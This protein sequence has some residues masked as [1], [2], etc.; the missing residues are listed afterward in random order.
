MRSGT[1]EF[2]NRRGFLARMT[3][4]ATPGKRD[5]RSIHSSPSLKGGGTSL[6]EAGTI[7][8]LLAEAHAS[9]RTE[10]HESGSQSR[11]TACHSS[12]HLD[13]VSEQ[14][15]AAQ[16]ALAASHQQVLYMITEC[17]EA[18]ARELRML[19][20]L[21]NSSDD[22]N[23]PATKSP[24]RSPTALVVP[25]P[26]FPS[27][28]QRRS[29]SESSAAHPHACPGTPGEDLP[30]QLTSVV[31]GETVNSNTP[32]FVLDRLPE[33][34]EKLSDRS[35]KERGRSAKHG[36][37]DIGD[38]Q[39][40]RCSMG[41]A[42]S[43]FA[44]LDQNRLKAKIRQSIAKPVYNVT[45]YYKSDG[46]WQS[47]ARSSWFEQLTLIVI[48][49]NAVWIGIDTD[50][51]KSVLLAADAFFI[52]MENFFCLFFFSE[53]VVRY[54]S[55]RQTLQALRDSWFVFDSILVGITIMET[56][57]MT[58]VLIAASNGSSGATLNLFDTDAS[59]LRLL[60]LL[61]LSRMAR[62]ARLFRA[63]PEL[64]I[65]M[66]GLVAAIRSVL[67]TLL[68]LTIIIYVFGIAFTSLMDGTH[69]GGAYFST[70]LHSMG[71][72]LLH[73]VFLE[74]I[75]DV[76]HIAAAESPF[77]GALLLLFVLIASFLVVNMLIGVMVETVHVVSAVER[78]QLSVTFTKDKLQHM[79]QTTNLDANGDNKIS[80]AEFCAL[81]QIPD[82]V[83]AL[84]ELGVDV[85]GLVDL[86]EFVFESGSQLEFPA[87]MDMVLQLRGS[88]KATVKDIVDLRKCMRQEI[89]NLRKTVERVAGF[90]RAGLSSC[91]LRAQG[92][93]GS[94]GLGT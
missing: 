12:A 49:I 20:E 42:S 16:R 15:V 56:W 86:S 66:K 74:D 31:P 28:A 81:L 78:E 69:P 22:N 80:K 83:R 63:I 37:L 27:E 6:A 90:E 79:L 19:T 70:V 39:K 89:N 65:V 50:Y 75:P 30:G 48:G 17:M 7:E 51:N 55:F 1:S 18:E 59:T 10:G 77:F 64:M 76:F 40:R 87:F 61:R 84:Q 11:T 91:H 34:T 33:K 54:M 94:S 5:N 57:V 47:V 2:P 52:V 44:D 29:S 32:P 3:D 85:V 71:T 35:D 36:G 46:F 13:C 26:S 58:L 73:G 21:G 38:S 41:S 14:L 8:A 88:N 43:M 45:D 53:W 4:L 24:V 62:M 82:A 72:L 67:V 93:R 92:L 9:F 60:R 68:M 23:I 25:C